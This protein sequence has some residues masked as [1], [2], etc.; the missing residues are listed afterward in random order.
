MNAENVPPI[1]HGKGIDEYYRKKREDSKREHEKLSK[2]IAEGRP[3]AEIIK[4]EEIA[5]R[6]GDTGD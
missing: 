3:R 4:Q 5:L 2:M 1:D 6:A